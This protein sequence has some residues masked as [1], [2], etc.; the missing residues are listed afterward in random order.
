ME[1]KDHP[2]YQQALAMAKASPASYQDVEFYDIYKD[3]VFLPVF[4]DGLLHALGRP[5]VIVVDKGKLKWLLHGRAL[6]KI[7]DKIS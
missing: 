1:S 7:L 6:E 5:R 4:N 2:L 3:G